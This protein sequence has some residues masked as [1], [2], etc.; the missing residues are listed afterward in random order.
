MPQKTRFKRIL[1]PENMKVK[2]F[3][4]TLLISFVFAL[5]SQAQKENLDAILDIAC[6]AVIKNKKAKNVTFN[7]E[8]NNEKVV[9][10][11]SRNGKFEFP[12][13]PSDG[14]YKLTISK[15]GFLTKTIEIDSYKMPF[16]QDYWIQELL[17]ECIPSSEG[18]VNEVLV[19]RLDYE[20]LSRAFSIKRSNPKEELAVKNA[21]KLAEVLERIYKKA[22]YNGDGLS[23]IDEYDYAKSFFEIALEAKPDD[24]Y[25]MT[26]IAEMDSLIEVEKTSPKKPKELLAKAENDENIE[27]LEAAK[28]E[29]TNTPKPKTEE[30]S[31]TA[32]AAKTEVSPS[33]D[34]PSTKTT[35]S[36]PKISDDVPTDKYYSVQLGA[37]VDW[38]DEKA[39]AN[40]PELMIVQGSDFKRCITGVFSDRE[41]AK[42][43]MIQ[44][45]ESG[46]K[47][48]FIVTMQ[49][50]ERVGF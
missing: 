11:V 37:F 29:N 10:I 49:G 8:L 2:L 9:E 36:S 15:E 27:K 39:F 21:V 44:M 6:Q 45:R 38:L 40:V 3:V 34:K 18:S 17:I 16:E 4:L 25:A 26:K 48:A 50:Q 5:Q 46:F 12:V 7:L 23:K 32:K 47:D 41:R 30:P 1:N 13:K 19:G 20:P 42:A 33:K 43:R 14:K 24:S 22:V 28:T 35:T 31:L